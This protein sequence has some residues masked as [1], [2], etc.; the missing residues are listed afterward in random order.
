[1]FVKPAT[2]LPRHNEISPCILL[3]SKTTSTKQPKPVVCLYQVFVYL[4]RQKVETMP[5][6]QFDHF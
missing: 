1:M 3:L 2:L 6:Y 5:H 4:A